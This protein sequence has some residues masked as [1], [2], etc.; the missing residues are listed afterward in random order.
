MTLVVAS[1]TILGWGVE[2]NMKPDTPKRFRNREVTA[3]KKAGLIT[4][5]QFKHGH[6]RI[7]DVRINDHLDYWPRSGKAWDRF[8]E[9]RYLVSVSL[10]EILPG[11]PKPENA[12]STKSRKN[13][14]LDYIN[15]EAWQLK[16]KEVFAQRG[17]SCERCG[18]NPA[19]P[20][21]HHKT[22]E[23]LGHEYLGDLMVLCRE[24][25]KLIHK[26]KSTRRLCRICK[27]NPVEL[28]DLAAKNP[29]RLRFCRQ[30]V[31]ERKAA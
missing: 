12:P 16:R 13:L 7:N 17:K 30:C 19:S 15:S 3:L 18:C 8:K 23:R 10:S 29:N 4:V 31:Q 26:R 1:N 27:A 24:C 22:Y 11:L 25:H 5:Q 6:V 21:V 14:Y 9:M 28:P 20:D 2:K